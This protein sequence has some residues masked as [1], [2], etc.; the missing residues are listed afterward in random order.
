[1]VT[2][3]NLTIYNITSIVKD[4]K[5]SNVIYPNL[6]V[7]HNL[8]I[9]AATLFNIIRVVNCI[10]R[11][12]LLVMN[13]IIVSLNKIAAKIWLSMELITG[14]LVQKIMAGNAPTKKTARIQI[15]Q[16]WDVETGLRKVMIIQHSPDAQTNVVQQNNSKMKSI[17]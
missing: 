10:Q 2:H 4:W 17:K 15:K 14:S 8:V 12:T 16:R 13:F 6:T 5:V 11:K 7:M 1:M 3:L 9:H